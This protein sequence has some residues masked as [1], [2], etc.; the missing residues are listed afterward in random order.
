LGRILAALFFRNI[1]GPRAE[2]VL[3]VFVALS[4]FGN[5][6][7]VIFSQGRCRIIASIPA[8]EQQADNVNSGSR[9]RPRRGLAVLKTVGEQQAIECTVYGSL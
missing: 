7:S 2:R 5:V 8:H 6:L 9:N 3:S 4:A 1:F